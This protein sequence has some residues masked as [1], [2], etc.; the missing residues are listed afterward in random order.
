MAKGGQKKAKYDAQKGRTAKNK[1]K[2]I[3][4]A[5][6]LGDKK[7]GVPRTQTDYKPKPKAEVLEIVKPK[8]EK[9][10]LRIVVEGENVLRNKVIQGEF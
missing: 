5:K 8:Q 4:K 6:L 2:N 10:D 3:A 1:A 9:S 7:A